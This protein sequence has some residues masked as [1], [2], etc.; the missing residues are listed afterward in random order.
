MG[1]FIMATILSQSSVRFSGR[2]PLAPYRDASRVIDGPGVDDETIEMQLAFDAPSLYAKVC[3]E[4]RA[5]EEAQKPLT[6]KMMN[7]LQNFL[8]KLRLCN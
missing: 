3:A 4:R 7:G 5:Q 8:R 2:D 1:V 6:R